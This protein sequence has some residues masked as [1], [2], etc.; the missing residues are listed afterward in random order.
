MAPG[1]VGLLPG[2]EVGLAGP[3]H[4]QEVPIAVAQQLRVPESRGTGELCAH[5]VVGTLDGAGPVRRLAMPDQHSKAGHS[6][7]ATSATLPARPSVARAVRTRFQ[8]R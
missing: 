7:I 2:G 6:R 5:F 3:L 4:H 1:P 8:S